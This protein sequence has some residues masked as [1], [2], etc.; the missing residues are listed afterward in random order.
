MVEVD[1]VFGERMNQSILNNSQCDINLSS[2]PEGM[3]FIYLKSD[4]R[5]EMGKVLIA[6]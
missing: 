6:R 2:Q 5:I 4:E 3:Y 1:N